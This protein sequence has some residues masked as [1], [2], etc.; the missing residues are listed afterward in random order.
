MS[1]GCKAEG[2]ARPK[3]F[4]LSRELLFVH[5]PSSQSRYFRQGGDLA[6][7]KVIRHHQ[8][9]CAGASA[10]HGAGCFLECNI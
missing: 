3:K 1:K 5:A 8:L 10:D 2:R 6:F 7:S 9:Y 4:H